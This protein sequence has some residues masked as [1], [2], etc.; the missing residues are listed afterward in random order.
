MSRSNPL[1][2]ATICDGVC[3]HGSPS[4]SRGARIALATSTL[5]PRSSSFCYSWAAPL[6][7]GD[8][9][10]ARGGAM[11][12]VAGEGMYSGARPSEVSFALPA[13]SIF[14][15]RLRSSGEV[16]PSAR[17][18]RRHQADLHSLAGRRLRS[19][20]ASGDLRVEPT[21]VVAARLPP[22]PP[23]KSRLAAG[24]VARG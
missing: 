6:M 21:A 18:V 19:L 13:E 2:L 11:T 12:R 8:R 20:G 14:S 15:P 7:G 23:L 4:G 17:A 9:L 3:G 10:C 5:R 16:K 22:G 24:M 1:L